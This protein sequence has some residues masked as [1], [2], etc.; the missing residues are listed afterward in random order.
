MG[1]FYWDVKWRMFGRVQG[2]GRLEHR[3]QSAQERPQNA[4]G[5]DG[6]WAQIQVR[7]CAQAEGR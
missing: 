6:R 1:H 5:R 3:G 7:A 2:Q 4:S